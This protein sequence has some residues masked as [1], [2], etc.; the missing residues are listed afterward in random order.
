MPRKS[1][2]MSGVSPGRP[3]NEREVAAL[4][5]MTTRVM[6]AASPKTLTKSSGPINGNRGMGRRDVEGA[7]HRQALTF[8]PQKQRGGG[9]ADQR[10][11]RAGNA[12]AQAFGGD[13]HGKTGQPEEQGRRPELVPML[14]DLPDAVKKAAGAARQSEEGG[15]L[16]DDDMHGYAGEKAGE[17]GDRQ[18]IGHPSGAK[19]AGA[20]HHGANHQRQH[21]G[22]GEVMRRSGSPRP[23][24]ARRRRS[25]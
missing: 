19:K 3:G 24:P 21:G 6:I 16:R 8:K 1:R 13:D 4:C 17:D 10:Q 12:R 23:A 18:Q 20:H 2:L 22:Q 5:T 7:D 9:R 14:E 11:Q 15:R 25:G